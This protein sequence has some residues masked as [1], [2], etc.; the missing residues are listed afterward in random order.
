MKTCN[1]FFAHLGRYRVKVAAGKYHIPQLVGLLSN[2]GVEEGVIDPEI[3]AAHGV[4]PP[5]FKLLPKKLEELPAPPETLEDLAKEEV[6]ELLR[7]TSSAPP[8]A[9]AE[10][11][12]KL[13]PPAEDTITA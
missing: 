4:L 13:A 11:T 1:A 8:T 3:A 9:P 2:L 5:G 7:R 6:V 12:T 10:E